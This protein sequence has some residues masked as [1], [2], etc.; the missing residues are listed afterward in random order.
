LL[1]VCGADVFRLANLSFPRHKP[2]VSIRLEMLQVARLAPKILGESAD[3]VKAFLLGRTTPDGAFQDRLGRADLYYTVFG[4]EGLMA[5]QASGP[6]E[7]GNF[8][9][10]FG[11]GENLDF[12][13]LCCLARCWATASMMGQETMP[14]D[15]AAEVAR[16]LSQFRAMDGGFHLNRAASRSTVYACFLGLAAY[17]DLRIALPEADR[18][19]DALMGLRTNDGAWANEPR[20]PVGATNATAAAVTALRNLARPV[21]AEVGDWL[22]ARCHEQGGFVAA[23]G[24][25]IPDLLSTATALHALSGLQRSIADI[26]ERCLDFV[27]SLWTN[28][29]S[30]HG[31]WEDSQLDVEYTYYGLL[32]LG[33]LSL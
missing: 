33:H 1:P 17:Y 20:I 23:P 31:H 11:R 9:R 6:P 3:L 14:A 19:A 32:A 27:D 22:K 25:P 5:L 15:A 29:G 28:E 21:G 18:L 4:L 13:H 16:T 2:A 30:F 24:V 8:L 10:Q 12:V 7:T 26:Q